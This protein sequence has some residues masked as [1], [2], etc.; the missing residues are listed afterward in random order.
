MKHTQPVLSAELLR[1]VRDN[2]PTV[3]D[4]IAR[5]GGPGGSIYHLLRKSRL[6]VEE[7]KHLHLDPERLSRDG[8]RFTY[9]I[10]VYHIDT[11]EVQF[12]R[13]QR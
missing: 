9:G 10:Q 2:R 6:L 7:G 5:F 3:E 11:G 13:R 12:V 4:F 8:K 1:F